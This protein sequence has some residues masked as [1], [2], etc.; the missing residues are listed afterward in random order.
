MNKRH[1]LL[2]S[3][4]AAGAILSSLALII[5]QA[6]ASSVNI[7]TFHLDGAFQTASGL[8]RLDAGQL[9]GK[10]FFPYLGIGPL[11]LIF[12]FFKIAGG[13]LAASVFATK[14][15][16]LSLGWISISVI[17]QLIFRSSK[18]F[19][20]IAGGAVFALLSLIPETSHFFDVFNFAREPGNSLRPIRASAPYVVGIFLYLL[21]QQQQ[22]KSRDMLA[23]LLVGVCLLWS[24]DF[25]IPTAFLIT[26]FFVGVCHFE[27]KPTWKKS[28]A[29]I[30]F[31][32][33]SS[34][35]AILLLVTAGHPME[36][37]KYNFVDVA[38]DQWWYFPS[39]QPSNRIFEASQ[40]TRIIS[41]QNYF[42]LGVLVFTSLCAVRTRRI[43]YALLSWIGMA[44]FSG[45]AV[46]SLGGQLGAYFGGFFYWGAV[47][48]LLLAAKAIQ[49]LA[50][51]AI[52]PTPRT[53]NSIQVGLV[54]MTFGALL[55]GVAQQWA[56][57]C[58]ESKIAKNDARRFYVPEFG[59]Y[60]ATGWKEYIDYARDHKDSRVIEEYWGILSS[61]NRSFPAWP[62]DAAIHAL[63][64]VRHAA[65]SSLADADLLV[66]TRFSTGPTWQQWS[67]SQNFWF[68]EEIL[69][70]WELDFV[71]PTTIVWRK[72][73]KGRESSAV[74][75]HVAQ[76]GGGF[77]LASEASGFYAVTVNYSATG[78]GRYL[79]MQKNNI[80]LPGDGYVSLPIGGS[81]VAIPVLKT[82][83]VG[84]FFDMKVVGNSNVTAS[85]TSCSAT[86]I[87]YENDEVLHAQSADS[88]NLS[89]FLTDENWD[90]G[91]ARNWAGFIVPNTA[92][93]A[94]DFMAGN[95]VKLENGDTR[96]IVDVQPAGKYLNIFVEGAIL[97][98]GRA[99]LPSHYVIVTRQQAKGRS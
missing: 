33:A 11:L 92:P 79:L 1:A 40:I 88:V 57:Y 28:L 52:Q 96:R 42:P 70:G 6:L 27:E 54:V 75:C 65:K 66:T 98:P 84:D 21:L 35:A 15:L 8:F 77:T 50:S 72:A 14:L 60:L 61:L 9:P 91:V 39:Y 13:T 34:W 85:V 99:G 89:F 82:P 30:I 10:D 73:A 47:T 46:A 4:A 74:D 67:L 93:Y 32:A 31:T 55:A 18:V 3:L 59:G 53:V 25:A 51:R 68:Y 62:V 36:L 69:S 78:A 49:I 90:Q 7:P 83:E 64:E 44:L 95:Y 80:S 43:E 76:N 20:L 23:G 86:R 16:T 41:E 81:T 2:I 38:N 22:G 12:P 45:G 63:G 87:S 94:R 71:S 19:S 26:V 48:A 29:I 97:S 37:I 5:I 56:K 24:N 58:Q 17:L